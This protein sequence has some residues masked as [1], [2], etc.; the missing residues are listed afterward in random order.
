LVVFGCGEIESE[1]EIGRRG[2][3]EERKRER[4]YQEPLKSSLLTPPSQAALHAPPQEP[5]SSLG[6]FV[7]YIH[8]A[9]K[10]SRLVI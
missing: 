8:G 4:E 3:K 2:I 6:P 10:P 9:M 1:R 7:G 5:V